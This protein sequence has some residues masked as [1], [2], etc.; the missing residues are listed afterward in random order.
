MFLI[1][2]YKITSLDDILFHKNIYK[3]II[4]GYNNI[5]H[6]KNDIKEII[7]K[8]DFNK[9]INKPKIYDNYNYMQH[10]LVYGMP[11]SGKNTFIKLLLNDIFDNSVNNTFTETYYIKGYGN[12]IVEIDI[13]QSKYH[14]IIEPKN[15]GLDKYII[16]E[17]VRD[18]AKKKIINN[19]FP[20]RIVLINNI[21]SLNFYAQFSLKSIMEK[22]HKTCRFILMSNQI[23][24]LIDP[25]TSRCLNIKFNYL[26]ESELKSYI[27]YIL[28]NEKI[29][30]SKNVIKNIIDNSD[31]NLKKTIWLIQMKIF[32]IKNYELSWTSSIDTFIDIMKN[33]FSTRKI[34]N[35]Q[36]INEKLIV[37]TR[38]ILY[39]I[40]TTNISSIDILETIINKII[41]SNLFD[42]KLLNKILQIASDVEKRLNISKRSTFH[43]EYFLYN[44]YNIIYNY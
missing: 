28:V 43:L 13:E 15:S 36:H 7:N 33:I 25:I 38:Y 40:F 5:S 26:S 42:V 41:N 37:I 17:I 39:N 32:N 29:L 6:D 30:F 8:K 3:N 34:N 11:G 4:I 20:F 24:K 2:K 31:F 14:L 21:E 44:V 10:L 35:N 1:D 12:A 23:S 16:L 9:L 18:Y 19:N 27:Y 22:Y